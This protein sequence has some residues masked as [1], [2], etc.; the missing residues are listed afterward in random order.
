MISP[1]GFTDDFKDFVD[2]ERKRASELEVDKDQRISAWQARIGSLFADIRGYLAGYS[3]SVSEG[4]ST[5]TEEVLGSYEVPTLSLE[6]GAKVVRIAPIGTMIFG[7]RG[8]VDVE[9]VAGRVR[10]VLAKPPFG[11]QRV[12]VVVVD[13]EKPRPQL[14]S[15]ADDEIYG[16]AIATD[17]PDVE[18]IRLNKENFLE[19][20]IAVSNGRRQSLG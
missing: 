12:K 3:V 14:Q 15:S 20:L 7:A 5:L 2:S 1:I 19:T 10:L 16:W 17:P 6:I 4:K 8:R 11:K 9:G 13:P 18:L